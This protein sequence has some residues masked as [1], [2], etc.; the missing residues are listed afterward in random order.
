M[1]WRTVLVVEDGEIDAKLL[2]RALA[3]KISRSAVVLVNTTTDAERY[4]FADGPGA[5][6]RKGPPDLVV[7]NVKAP[8][9]GGLDLL[10]KVRS[11]SRTRA[12]PVLAMSQELQDQDVRDLYRSGANSYMDRP[13]DFQEFVS[14]V[15]A[16]A[17]YWLG[18]NLSAPG[19]R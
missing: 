6:T 2:E 11:D 19:T 1:V 12:I 18:L 15:S 3:D 5:G 4:L 16:A 9:S 14:M 7:L 17:H 10:K 13:V 8:P